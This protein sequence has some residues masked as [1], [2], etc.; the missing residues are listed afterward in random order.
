MK[1]YL[2]FLCIV[3]CISCANEE[4]Q[5][6]KLIL[7]CNIHLSENKEKIDNL[8]LIIHKKISLE[9]NPQCIIGGINKIIISETNKI[10]V[11]DRNKSKSI[12]IFTNDG[13]YLDKI[14]HIGKAE[15]EFMEIR[16]FNVQ[17]NPEVIFI[18][19]KR[20]DKILEY[21][22]HLKF[23]KERK[24]SSK[25]NNFQI[26]KNGNILIA[27]AS[28]GDYFLELWD[29]DY[30]PIKKF[31]NKPDYLKPYNINAEFFLNK[32][33][34]NGLITF[35]VPFSNEVIYFKNNDAIEAYCINN[36][37]IIPEESFF[38]KRKGRHPR[39]IVQELFSSNFISFLETVE[40]NEYTFFK[41]Y[42]NENKEIT[43]YDKS[44]NENKTYLITKSIKSLVLSNTIAVTPNGL[45][46]SYIF[47]FDA[48]E[49]NE[50]LNLKEPIN[51]N[52][53]PIIIYYSLNDT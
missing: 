43:V 8:N 6:D 47:P 44:Q 11:L 33:H 34:M 4:H 37:H 26:L 1:K 29:N 41:Y 36:E 13:K 25:F 28:N 52:N 19:D 7:E 50:L 3:F 35:I 5:Q 16:D 22:N 49:N 23:L 12:F 42:K 39:L 21:D 30:I 38:Q 18:Y 2:L 9:K 24:V 17:N 20:L 51:V 53:N 40:N 46:V 14:N 27:T 48:I 10:L 32:N 15:G 45:F 31:Y